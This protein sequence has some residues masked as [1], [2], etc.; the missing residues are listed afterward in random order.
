MVT[1]V[2]APLIVVVIKI[3]CLYR[4]QPRCPPAGVYARAFGYHRVVGGYMRVA[5]FFIITE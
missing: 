3:E 1:T 4:I 5:L 2:L